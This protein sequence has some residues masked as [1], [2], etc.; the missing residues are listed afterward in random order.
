MD[1]RLAGPSDPDDVLAELSGVGLGHGAHPSSGTS[2]HH[3]SD[4]TYPCS[5]PLLD[6][7]TDAFDP[8]TGVNMPQ[9]AVPHAPRLSFALMGVPLGLVATFD[10]LVTR[11]E[12]PKDGKAGRTY[13]RD[14]TRLLETWSAAANAAGEYQP[15]TEAALFD[16]GT[17]HPGS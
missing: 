2:R 9:P 11:F 14:R 16:N 4:V 5:S 3:R 6:A 13:V 7:A 15:A 17:S 10:T 8:D 1:S 12:W